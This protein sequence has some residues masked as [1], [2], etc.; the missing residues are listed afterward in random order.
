[1]NDQ[2]DTVV[3]DQSAGASAVSTHPALV[4]E[5]TELPEPV[6]V[7][8]QMDQTPETD[9]CRLMA[10]AYECRRTE[11][12]AEDQMRVAALVNLKAAVWSIPVDPTLNK[13]VYCQDDAGEP[14]R[15][16]WGMS[17]SII[18]KLPPP[19]GKSTKAA[20]LSKPLKTEVV[21][22]VRLRPIGGWLIDDS[23]IGIDTPMLYE[24]VGAAIANAL[25]GR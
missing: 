15:E 18:D 25:Y 11:I 7:A 21:L 4:P 3:L 14:G 12:A 13:E 17:I 1:M 2:T 5:P 8:A 10:D 9:L 23:T 19:K 22:S 6:E 24:R 20:K 16:Q